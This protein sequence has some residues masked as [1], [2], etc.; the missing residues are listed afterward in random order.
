MSNVRAF[1]SEEIS[2]F[3]DQIA[4]LLNGGIPIYEGTHILYEEM[5]AGRTK[6]VLK[7]VDEN[8]KS[9]LSFSE[10]LKESK[11]FP[12]YLC[13]MVAIGETTGKL[14]DIMHSLAGYYER[15]SV[16][17]NSIR[18][19]ISYPTVLF[20]NDGGHTYCACC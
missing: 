4:M 12:D 5:D 14:E 19:V 8:V 11:A 2:A 20:R 3:C 1:S 18:S 7:R 17:K 9:G 16:I 13:E 10:A 6:D 15:E